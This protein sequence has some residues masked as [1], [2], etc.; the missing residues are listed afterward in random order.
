MNR[1]LFI[2]ALFVFCINFSHSVYA[3]DKNDQSL[4]DDPISRMDTMITNSIDRIVRDF[5]LGNEPDDPRISSSATL[6]EDEAQESYL[7]KSLDPLQRKLEFGLVEK[8]RAA[9]FI[10]LD[11]IYGVS[12]Q[13]T[14]RRAQQHSFNSIT[15]MLQDCFYQKDNR[16]GDA[17]ALVRIADESQTRLPFYEW[18]SSTQSH[19]TNYSNYRYSTW[20]L[21]C[22][23][24]D[25]E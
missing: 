15:I 13:V 3:T 22:I 10:I 17:L 16:D 23:I 4:V 1:S 20:L 21:R 6:L 19:L 12:E 25:Q 18:F 2:N 7:N 5:F 8:A 11:K 24:S 9:Q 14:V